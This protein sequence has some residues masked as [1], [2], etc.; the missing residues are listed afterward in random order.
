MTDDEKVN[1]WYVKTSKADSVEPPACRFGRIRSKMRVQNVPN[2]TGSLCVVKPSPQRLETD[3][4]KE[5]LDTSHG[6][7]R[8]N[9]GESVRLVCVIEPKQELRN[10]ANKVRWQFGVNDDSFG[11]LPEGIVVNNNELLIERTN[12]IHRGYYN[13]TLNNVSFVVLLRVK[14]Q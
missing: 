4:A 6:S 3:R 14:G 7:V 1:N 11:D 5:K 8:R 2:S 12:K 10:A 13:C 9:L